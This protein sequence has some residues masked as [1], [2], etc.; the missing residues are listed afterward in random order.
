MRHVCVLVEVRDFLA[1]CSF[2]NV[3]VA[4]LRNLVGFVCAA[5]VFGELYC[6]EQVLFEKIRRFQ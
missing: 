1:N 4:H 6:Q 5:F 3:L 2:R